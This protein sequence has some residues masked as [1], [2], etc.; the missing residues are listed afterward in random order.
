MKKALVLAG[1]SDQIALISELHKRQFTVYLVDYFDNPPARAFAD[2]HIKGSTLDIDFVT[3]T[4]IAENVDII[5]TACTDQ[6]LLTMAEVSEALSLPCYIPYLTARNVTNK[7]YM[8]KIMRENGIP[9]ADY[10]VVH[11]I[12]EIDIA[13][14]NYPIVVKP[15]DC[16]SSKGVKKVT[17]AESAISTLKEALGLSRT[18]TAIIEDFKTG[19]ELSADFIVTGGRARLLCVTES[20]KIPDNHGA[21]TILQSSFPACTRQ[22]HTQIEQIGQKIA[23]AFTLNECPLLV[24]LIRAHDGMYVLEFSAR[25][26]GGSKYKLIEVLS[27]IDIMSA[28]TD[29]ALGKKVTVNPS[30]QIKAAKMNYVYCR[31]GVLESLHNFEELKADGIIAEYFQ[32]KTAGMTI[33]GAE[34]SGDRPAG[35]L[36]TG[37]SEEEVCRKLAIADSRLQIISDHKSDIMIHGLYNTS[38]S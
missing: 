14:L 38:A 25:M 15:A 36:I 11:D 20:V 28:Y 8:K 35:F 24:Q 7:S 18:H 17:G 26:G 21:F 2:K 30:R 37:E 23:E 6:A 31:N 33:T 3:K 29:M 27:G 9:T 13:T 12:E 32:Y 34:T 16:N 4:A 22:E 5:I 1:G 10:H 19:Q